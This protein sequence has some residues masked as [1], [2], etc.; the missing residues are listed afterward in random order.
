MLHRP[1]VG[2]YEC[3]Q[4]Q[5]TM[6]RSWFAA[7]SV[8]KGAGE[9]LVSGAHKPSRQTAPLCWSRRWTRSFLRCRSSTP[10]SSRCAHAAATTAVHVP[11]G[12]RDGD[13]VFMTL[14]H[15]LSGSATGP[16][17]QQC[18]GFGLQRT[19]A[20]TTETWWQ[21][22]SWHTCATGGWQAT[23]PHTD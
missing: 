4:F 14:D 6:E 19:T 10:P 15:I 18:P 22:H 17:L 12:N 11:Q 21:R 23:L 16:L 9:C 5:D 20:A 3:R 1:G 7:E 8:I 13:G 2:V